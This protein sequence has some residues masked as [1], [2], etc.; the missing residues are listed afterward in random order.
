MHQLLTDFKNSYDS[1]KREVLY[2]ILLEFG[3]P[4]KVIRLIKMCLSEIY[5]K[6]SV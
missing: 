6:I 4:K 2:N 3:T 5:S 1:V